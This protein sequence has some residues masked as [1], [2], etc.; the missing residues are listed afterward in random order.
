MGLIIRSSPIHAAGCYTTSTIPKGSPVVEYTGP[1]ITK[2]RADKLYENSP[3]TYLFGVGDGSM[4][5]DG[6]GTAMFIN[7]S[8]DPN[9]EADEREDRVWIV[10]L[11][12]IAPGEELTYDYNLYDGD[13]D[14][15]RCNCGAQN[16][17]QTMYSPEEV[18]R[19]KRAGLKKKTAK[20][21]KAAEKKLA[22]AT[23]RPPGSKRNARS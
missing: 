15:A 23:K 2:A 19:R 17:R 3:M 14:D 4:V 13:E 12:K 10:A 18:L 16:C 21:K 7:H 11:R 5:I 22:K 9:C 20:K 6:H 1:R 8:C